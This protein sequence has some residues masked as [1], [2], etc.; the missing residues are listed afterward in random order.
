MRAQLA[1]RAGRLRSTSLSAVPP[2]RTSADYDHELAKAAASILYRTPVPSDSGL[3]IYILNAAALP[4]ADEHDFDALLPYVLARLPGEEELLS[5]TE[6][7]VIFFAG[8]DAERAAGGKRNR[9]GWG[10]FIQAYHVLSRAMRKRLQKL[11]IVHERSWVRIL[12]E[13]FST[14]VSPKFRR[15]IVHV[16]TL[17]QLAL[18]MPIQTLL[19]PPSAYLH[20]RRLSPD[21]YAPFA[22]GRRAFSVKHPLPQNAEGDTR[23]PRVLRET[24][25]FL[26]M[27]PNIRTEGIFRIPPHSRLKEILKEAYDRGQKY[28]LWKENGVMLPLPPFD[29]SDSTKAIVEEVDSR[30]CYGV[31]L[32]AGLI[33]TWYA[34]LRQPIFPQSSYREVRSLFGNPDEPP[35]RKALMELISPKSEWSAIPVI[36]REILVR[37][38]LPLLSVVAAHQDDNKMTAENLAVCFAPTLVCGPDQI[39]DAKMSSVVRRILAEAIDMWDEGLREDCG[40]NETSFQRDLRSPQTP[41]EYEDPLEAAPKRRPDS[42][43]FGIESPSEEDAGFADSEKQFS[44]I[45]LQDNSKEETPPALPPRPSVSSSREMPLSPTGSDDSSVRRKPAPS[46]QVP[47]RYSAVLADEMGGSSAGTQSPLTYAATTDGFAPARSTGWNVDEKKQDKSSARLPGPTVPHIIVPKRKALTAEQIASAEST[48]SSPERAVSS[49]QFSPRAQ[50]TQ[51]FSAQGRTPPGLAEMIGAA[52]A[53]GAVHRKPISSRPGSSGSSK[54]STPPIQSPNLTSPST[55]STRRPSLSPQDAESRKPV[56]FPISTSNTLSRRTSTSSLTADNAPGSEY[57]RERSRSRGPTIN[58]LARPVYPAANSPSTT[59][60]A[61]LQRAA[62]MASEP[63]AKPR[64]MSSGLLKRMPSFE[65]PP[66]PKDNPRKL[67]LKKKSV[68]DL[69]RL[70]EER[71]GAAEKLVKLGNE[72]MKVEGK[73]G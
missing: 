15:K 71:A 18:H 29:Q 41:H 19:I 25:T 2:P 50:N 24:T 22:S 60:S 10:W 27:D 6:Y 48:V 54:P 16:S 73:K 17:T 37:H 3:P 72:K 62:T 70:F 23:L 42:E 7:E 20:D 4:D 32:S 28:I 69:R 49:P 53:A 11:Y 34:E 56:D 38:L 31:Y 58:S 64:A 21:I 5:G 39:E 55:F 35:T 65:P 26:L 12:V 45:I 44:G 30:D 40:I 57:T 47:P 61:N 1:Q 59:N 52:A 14:I 68:E 36:S 66:I 46:V 43:D 67:D 63:P 13:M 8:G 51:T 9:P 33:K